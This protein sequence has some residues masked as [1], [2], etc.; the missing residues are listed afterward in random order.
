MSRKGCFEAIDDTVLLSSEISG[1]P[2]KSSTVI[3]VLSL[4]QFKQVCCYS[5]L[6]QCLCVNRVPS[7]VHGILHIEVLYLSTRTYNV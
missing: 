5:A 6:S 1:N 7:L 3:K 4:V 2:E